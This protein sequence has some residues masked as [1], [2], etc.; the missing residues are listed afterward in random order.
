MTFLIRGSFALT[1][2]F[3]YFFFFYREDSLISRRNS[4]LDFNYNVQRF[5]QHKI[6]PD[7]VYFYLLS[8]T[9]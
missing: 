9:L 8:T 2:K 1:G 5:L 4:C 6:L 7:V 3:Y